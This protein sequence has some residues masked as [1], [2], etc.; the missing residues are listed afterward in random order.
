MYARVISVA[1]RTS[2][3]MHN[4]VEAGVGLFM[5]PIPG[6]KRGQLC[7]RFETAS[8]AHVSHTSRAG[9]SALRSARLPVNFIG[10][11]INYANRSIGS[12]ITSQSTAGGPLSVPAPCVS[13]S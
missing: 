1:H 3:I 5:H 9:P 2:E 10:S 4:L 11:P 6:D 7:R 12:P 13:S 8:T